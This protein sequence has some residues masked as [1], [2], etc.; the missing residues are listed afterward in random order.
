MSVAVIASAFVVPV[1]DASKGWLLSAS[2]TGALDGGGRDFF[3]A[4]QDKSPRLRGPPLFKRLAAE[5]KNPPPAAAVPVDSGRVRLRY[6]IPAFA[7]I[8]SCGVCFGRFGR[9]WLLQAVDKI[10]CP[11]GVRSGG[12]NR[13]L[14][15]LEDLDP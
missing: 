12:K 7:G 9:G 1:P 4:Q 6:G 8:A 3:A 10:R 14:V 2:G 13:P 15:V 11:L 5:L